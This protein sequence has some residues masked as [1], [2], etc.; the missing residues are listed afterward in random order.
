[1]RTGCPARN[2]AGFVPATLA[3]IHLAALVPAPH[4]PPPHAAPSRPP[5]LSAAE[6]RRR[7]AAFL[8]GL[9]HVCLSGNALAAPPRELLEHAS[10]GLRELDLSYNRDL[11]FDAKAADA[12]AQLA[13]CGR[14]AGRRRVRCCPWHPAPAAALRR[15]PRAMMPPTLARCSPGPAALHPPLHPPRSLELLR[16]DKSFWLMRSQAWTPASLRALGR[17]RKRRPDLA[18]EGLEQRFAW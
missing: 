15:P 6:Y 7:A 17:L 8:S 2:P 14:W 18:V 10:S 11:Q 5:Q 13:G 1:M 3:A 12:L 4:A 16:L 9:T